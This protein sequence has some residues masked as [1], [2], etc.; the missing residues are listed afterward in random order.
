MK[1]SHLHPL[2]GTGYSEYDNKVE[3]VKKEWKT[4][5][6]AEISRFSILGGGDPIK[7]EGPTTPVA[8]L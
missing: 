1:N 8:S 2:E 7:T 3:I 5:E 6:V 4:P